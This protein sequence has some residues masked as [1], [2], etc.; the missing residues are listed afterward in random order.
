MD[1][2]FTAQSIFYR[3]SPSEYHLK[4]NKSEPSESAPPDPL[5]PWSTKGLL[6]LNS[7]LDKEE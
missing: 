4:Q 5:E 1:Y 2:T 6:S 7:I 3:V